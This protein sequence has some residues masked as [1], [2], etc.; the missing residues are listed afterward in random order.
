MVHLDT[1]SGE[2]LESRSYGSRLSPHPARLSPHHMDGRLSPHISP[3]ID[4]RLSP[5]HMMDSRIS[6]LHV[7]PSRESKEKGNCSFIFI[8]TIL[9]KLIEKKIFVDNLVGRS[10]ILCPQ[11]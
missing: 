6:P 11:I 5:R 9:G 10:H 4:G 7:E 3:R 8:Y 2:E 1:D